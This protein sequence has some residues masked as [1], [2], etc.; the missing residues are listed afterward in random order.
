MR[1]VIEH[2]RPGRRAA[3]NDKTPRIVALQQRRQL[4][5]KRERPEIDRAADDVG[6]EGDHLRGDARRVAP[7][8]GHVPDFD[9]EIGEAEARSAAS[10]MYR[11]RLGMNCGI[12]GSRSG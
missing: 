3:E 11:P 5:K 7:P 6:I 9:L 1:F 12:A 4:E 8:A 2:D 10:T